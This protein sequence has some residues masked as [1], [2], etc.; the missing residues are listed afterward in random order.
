MYDKNN[1]VF[2]KGNGQKEWVSLRNINK[3]LINATIST[4]DKRFYKHNGFDYI[5]IIKSLFK[6]IKN[7]NIVE[8]GSTI[9]QQY[10]RNLYLNF[11]RKW[12]RKIKEAF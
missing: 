8:G 12:S 5:R 9:T 2:Y 1:K 6:N 10:A 3:D 4:E 11:D 7:K